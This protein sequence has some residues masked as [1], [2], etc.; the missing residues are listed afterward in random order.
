[1]NAVICASLM[2]LSLPLVGAGV[3][4][5]EP[6]SGKYSPEVVAT[7]EQILEEAGLRRTGKSIQASNTATISRAISGLAREKRSLRLVYQDWKKVVDQ[8]AAIRQELQRLNLQYGEYNLQLARVAGVDVAAN[9]RIVGLLNATNAKMKVLTGERERLKEELALKRE[10]L[11]QA[12]SAYAETVLAIRRDFNDARDK[13]ATVLADE[14]VLI[15]IRVMKTN[16]ETPEALTADKILVS[17]D[18]RIQRIEQEIFSE[19]IQLEV[20]RGSLYVDVVVGKKTTRM[21]VDSGATLISL[22]IKT[23]TELGITVPVDAREMKLILADGRTIPARGVTIPKVR[24]GEFEAENVE[25]A[26]LDAV[27]SDAE[28]LLGMSFL[29]NFKFEINTADK[30]LKMLRVDAE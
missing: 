28:P 22:P 7:A 1:M 21:V 5:Q 8:I 26:V 27:A 12:E 18:K 24:V 29:G 9:N 20:D 2:T 13:L 17:L 30:T 4:A 3:K 11:N 23:A 19:S 6:E 25:A 16:Y 15:A 14:K 10:A